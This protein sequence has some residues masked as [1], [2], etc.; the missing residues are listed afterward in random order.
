MKMSETDL[1]LLAR[2]KGK[3]AEDAF[4]EIVRRHL[5][6][7]LS[8]ALRK[9]R[10]PQLA[11]EVAQSVFSDL[12]QQADGLAPDTVLPG[13]LYQVTCRTAIDVIR[14]ESRRQSREQVALE[15]TAMNAP[16]AN[17]TE[18][19][20]LLDEAMHALDET[21][22]TAVLLRYFKN[23]SLREVGETLGTSEEAARKRITRAVERMRQFFTKRG[24]TVG[25]SGLAVVISANAVQAAP[26]SLAMK[27][28]TAALAGKA[29]TAATA[30][31]LKAITTTAKGAGVV[32]GA[33]GLGTLGGF[34]AMLGGTFVT[35]RAQADDTKSPRERQFLLRMIGLRIVTALVSLAAFYGI[36]QISN[37]AFAH[38][39]VLG[40]FLFVLAV[41]ITLL[42]DY[43]GRHQRQ[44]QIEEGTFSEAEWKAP[45][46]ETD[47]ASGERSRMKRYFKAAGFLA[48]FLVW[49]AIMSIEAPWKQARARA[50]I[51]SGGLA[52]T[53]ALAFRNW[54][55]RPR[56]PSLRPG[57]LLLI[58]G[59]MCGLTLLHYNLRQYESGLWISNAA[60]L[61]G[62]ILFNAVVL[63]IYAAFIC[64]FAWKRNW[65]SRD[66]QGSRR[67]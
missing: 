56:F 24:V 8:A 25:A 51:M 65:I 49:F 64:S 14:R 4:T 5:D 59:S 10:S 31:G 47:F 6:L 15:L 3:N 2:Y 39:M 26:T 36:R 58:S 62:V 20:P 27:I 30:S 7:V 19:E 60:A 33:V 35:L 52:I 57:G 23:K 63:L 17:W 46:R 45:R 21:D 43:T 9:V 29:M 61:P 11:E 22:R 34:L 53:L 28:A 41:C 32:K 18:V 38:E 40:A 1:Q 55:R 44:I 67:E 42:L 54:Q 37:D 50:A 16:A 66:R 48:F 13:W 12:A